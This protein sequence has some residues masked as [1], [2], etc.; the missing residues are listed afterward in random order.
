MPFAR[1]QVLLWKLPCQ[2]PC[3]IYAKF[4]ENGYCFLLCDWLNIIPIFKIH[5]VRSPK[6]ICYFHHFIN[7]CWSANVKSNKVQHFRKLR[8]QFSWSLNGYKL[9]NPLEY[10]V[11]HGMDSME[12]IETECGIITDSYCDVMDSLVMFLYFWDTD[13]I[14]LKPVW[15]LNILKHIYMAETLTIYSKNK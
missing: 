10:L 3:N 1:S 12:S 14:L 6:Q 8:I 4:T 2:N 11:M 9:S 5:T 7:I 15:V 13:G